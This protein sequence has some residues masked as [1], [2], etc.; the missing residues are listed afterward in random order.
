MRITESQ[1]RKVIRKIVSEQLEDQYDEIENLGNDLAA[2][3]NGRPE[4]GAMINSAMEKNRGPDPYA[5]I[6]R[7]LNRYSHEWYE[8][9]GYPQAKLAADNKDEIIEIA[10]NQ[11]M[12]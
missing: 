5:P 9:L 2:W 4:I 3:V 1:L 12:R 10:A 8:T 11:F 6:Y 7:I